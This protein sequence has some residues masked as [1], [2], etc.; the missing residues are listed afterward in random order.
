MTVETNSHL[1]ARHVAKHN[2]ISST[3]VGH[4]EPVA[5]LGHLIRESD[6]DRCLGS[7]HIKGCQN[8]GTREGL[9]WN[10]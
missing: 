5:S 6:W 7:F 8:R 4:L 10:R 2:G 1:G 3:L 9:A